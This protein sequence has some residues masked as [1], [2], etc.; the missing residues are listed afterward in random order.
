MIDNI[1]GVADAVRKVCKRYISMT[2]ISYW[3]MKKHPVPELS[4][5]RA[6]TDLQSAVFVGNTSDIPDG[7][8]IV[9]AWVTEGMAKAIAGLINKDPRAWMMFW[10][11]IERA[12]FSDWLLISINKRAETM[13]FAGDY[14]TASH[15]LYSYM[16][17]PPGI[18]TLRVALPS[19]TFPN[20]GGVVSMA[21]LVRDLCPTLK[22]RIA[23]ETVGERMM[24]LA[25]GERE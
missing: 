3:G 9:Q 4:G 7:A 13:V 18:D 5:S 12:D 15:Y 6:D 24:P 23:V 22:H 21:L 2:Q 1:P 10:P 14:A 19:G 17:D 20:Y 16:V 11:M 8:I 25:K